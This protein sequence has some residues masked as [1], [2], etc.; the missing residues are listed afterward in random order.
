MCVRAW[1][2]ESVTDHSVKVKE[3]PPVRSFNKKKREKRS[4]PLFVGSFKKITMHS[5]QKRHNT[6]TR[7]QTH[8]HVNSHTHDRPP[9][10]KS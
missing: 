10:T 1:L 4:P 6:H 2:S 5:E 9:R 8:K 3:E 7:T